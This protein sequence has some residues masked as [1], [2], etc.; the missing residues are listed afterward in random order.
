[1]TDEKSEVK[2]LGTKEVATRLKM[3][4]KELRSLLRKINGKASGERYEWKTDDPFLKKL[5]Q[6]I[7]AAKK[8]GKQ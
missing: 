3:K 7:K 1:M 4:P 5:P 8:G 6:L 2:M